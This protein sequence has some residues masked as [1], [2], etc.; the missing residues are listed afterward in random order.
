MKSIFCHGEGI[1]LANTQRQVNGNDC[2]V[3]AIA[4]ATTL[5]FHGDTSKLKYQ[6]AAMR[7]HLVRS[8]EGT[9]YTLSNCIAIHKVPEL[10]CACMQ[11]INHFHLYINVHP[12]ISLTGYVKMP[13]L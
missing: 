7:I 4:V 12:C 11:Y 8:F 2:G 6:Q 5:A 10:K 3:Y 1:N 13:L 9:I